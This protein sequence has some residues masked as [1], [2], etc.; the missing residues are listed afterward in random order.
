M[1][2]LELELHK[3]NLNL[4]EAEEAPFPS[5]LKFKSSIKWSI[6]QKKKLL[7]FQVYLVLKDHP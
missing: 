5:P 3:G 6:Y 1:T 7:S 4:L 2:H